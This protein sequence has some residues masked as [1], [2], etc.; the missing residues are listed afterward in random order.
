MFRAL[1][2]SQ[3]EWLWFTLNSVYSWQNVSTSCLVIVNSKKKSKDARFFFSPD[4]PLSAKSRLPTAA[5]EEASWPTKIPMHV[6]SN[7]TRDFLQLLFSS[8]SNICK[9][10]P[11]GVKISKMEIGLESEK[12]KTHGYRADLGCEYFLLYFYPKC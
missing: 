9:V 8:S 1:A 10:F 11:P 5:V 3:S 6:N 7:N 4:K 2:L 12:W